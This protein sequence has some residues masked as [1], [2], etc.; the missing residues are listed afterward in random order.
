M[1][2]GIANGYGIYKSI[3]LWIEGIWKNNQMNGQGIMY[4][5]YCFKYIGNF[6]NCTPNGYGTIKFLDGR[7]YFR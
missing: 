1:K 2:K 4:K 6:D 5:R 3:G 7:K